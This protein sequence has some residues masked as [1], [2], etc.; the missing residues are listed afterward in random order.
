M[1]NKQE[2]L[3]L[4]C[5]QEDVLS[6][7]AALIESGYS[8]GIKLEKNKVKTDSYHCVIEYYDEYTIVYTKG[9]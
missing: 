3:T 4:V 9:N 8:V 7:V 1:E 6:L 2:E 5:K